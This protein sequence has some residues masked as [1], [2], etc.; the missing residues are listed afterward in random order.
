MS[1]RKKR[2]KATLSHRCGAVAPESLRRGCV[3][4]QLLC[5]LKRGHPGSHVNW[6]DDNIRR[7]WMPPAGPFIANEYP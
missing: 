6:R 5:Q 2:N 1:K 7:V 4:P 3:I